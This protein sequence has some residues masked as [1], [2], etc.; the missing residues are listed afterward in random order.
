MAECQQGIAPVLKTLTPGLDLHGDDRLRRDLGLGLLL[1]LVLSQALLADPGRL[2]VLLLVV[3][4]K[5]VDVLLRLGVFGGVHSHLAGLR[6]V[7]AVRLR[8]I[9]GKVGEISLMRGDVLVP[10]RG[11]GV[12][13]GV[14]A[15]LDGLVDGN[16]SLR[17]R[18]ALL[19]IVSH[20]PPNVKRHDI[21]LSRT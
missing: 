13:L 18:V 21:L 19:S 6:A 14:R 5:E 8:G 9:A 3:A 7:A 11:M 17:G 1:L 20:T 16:I 15:G 12:L 4:A 2:L 10:A